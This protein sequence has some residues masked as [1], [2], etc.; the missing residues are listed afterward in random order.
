MKAAR[1]KQAKPRRQ[2]KQ[3]G[4]VQLT[5]PAEKIVTRASS[6]PEKPSSSELSTPT[7][8]ATELLL[9]LVMIIKNEAHGIADTLES[10]RPYIDYWTILDTGS[11]D[12]TQDV[13]KRV[14]AN[15]PGQLIEEP[16]V[17]F[18]TSRNRA[19]D[20]HGLRTTFTIMPD[21]DDRLVHGETL[22]T[23]VIDNA[24]SEGIVHEAYDVC[25]HRGSS[26]YYLPILLRAKCRW[27]YRGRVHEYCGRPGA[28][29]AQLRVPSV[30]VTKVASEKSLAATRAR[31]ERDLVLLEA[32]RAQAPTDP[33]TLFYLAQ[34]YDCLGR[35][36]EAIT[37]Y[38]E[39]VRVGGWAEETFEAAM[40]I[41]LMLARIDRPWPEIQQA[42]L[43]AHTFDPKRAEPL[44]AI[45]E[46]YYYKHDNLPLTFL[47][48][49]RA[50]ELPLPNATLFVEREAYEWKAAHLVSIAGYYLG[51]DAWHVGKAGAD[52]ALASGRGPEGLIRTNRSCYVGSAYER[53]LA[54]TWRIP[55][56]P[57]APFVA[58]NPSVHYDARSDQW[59]CLV[60]TLNYQI[61]NGHS[62]TPP[63]DTIFTRNVMTELAGD[64]AAGFTLARVIPMLDRDE[65]PRTDFKVH[66]FE[67]CRL[68]RAGDKFYCTA[69]VCDF[70]MERYGL[71]EIVLCE[72][73]DDYSIIRATPL[74]GRWSEH[75]QK[76]WM[77]VANT[78]DQR[79]HIAY[80]LTPRCAM[81]ALDIGKRTVDASSDLPI[82]NS[83]LRGGSQLVPVGGGYLCLVHDV[84]HAKNAS[85]TYLHRF[86]WLDSNF[87]TRKMSD[88]FYFEKKGIEYAA[89]L[90]VDKSGSYLV[91]SYS[92]NDS[93]ANLAIFGVDAVMRS[94]RDDY[95]V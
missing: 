15:I 26:T 89:G 1:A 87:V 37:Y 4:R 22:R 79:V 28:P 44:V 65:T 47:F 95:V 66:G 58:A 63:D 72:L 61:V 93:S 30:E 81:I 33:R 19:L 41:A 2:T 84:I 51:G 35:T 25:I 36:E 71:R 11:T 54:K 94:L 14:L 43:D 12:G 5:K 57:E 59:R 52:R 91:A 64:P 49:R 20:L 18:S 21:S 42:Y 90:A 53:Y 55:Y 74:R 76:N 31:W 8:P 23:Y 62:Y 92:V 85:R 29:P 69:T 67:D 3:A 45:A 13:V 56:A 48:A 78:S 50:M 86:V 80:A 6:V 68:F 38:R 40:R 17:D 88:L 10:F 7:E 83:H 77:P 46:H 16:F 60:R 27:R 24:K 70:N 75:D 32:D 34:T 82:A 9:G 73:A 39:R